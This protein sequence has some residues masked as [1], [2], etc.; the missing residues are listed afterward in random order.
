MEPAA[1]K[2]KNFHSNENIFAINEVNADLT[3]FVWPKLTTKNYHLRPLQ[4][5]KILAH[6]GYMT[7]LW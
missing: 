4:P 6:K 3:I 1:K 2:R 5:V 7:Y